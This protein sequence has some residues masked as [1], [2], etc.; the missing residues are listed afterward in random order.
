MRKVSA[1]FVL[2]FALAA[3]LTPLFFMTAGA[4]AAI[5][6]NHEKL[7]ENEDYQYSY[8]RFQAAMSEA[9]ERLDAGE[10]KALERENDEEIASSVKS[11]MESGSSETEAYSMAFDWRAEHIGNVLTWDWLRKNAK[12]AVGYYRLESGAFDGYMTVQE[13]D[14]EGMYAVLI[15]A[16]QKGGAEN[17]GELELLGRLEGNKITLRPDDEKQDEAAEVTFD[18]EKARVTTSDAFKEG[19]WLGAGV[20]LDGEYVREKK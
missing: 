2:T 11:D 7:M 16:I 6:K 13:G 12:G 14:E 8:N 5:P 17:S 4:E 3:A 19:G 20:F 1:I 9:K 18:G 15:H 10:Y